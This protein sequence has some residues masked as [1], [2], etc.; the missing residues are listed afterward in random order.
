MDLDARF[1]RVHQTP[2]F[3]NL[4]QTLAVFSKLKDSCQRFCSIGLP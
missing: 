2:T 1:V 4:F 3:D